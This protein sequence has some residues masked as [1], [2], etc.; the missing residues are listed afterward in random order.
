MQNN[1]GLIT[2]NQMS[3]CDTSSKKQEK[4]VNGY[5]VT[6]VGEIPIVSTE[7]SKKDIRGRW[8]ARWGIG[9]MSYTIEPGLSGWKS[10]WWR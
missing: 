9:R 1:Q 3:C 8:K 2:I 10:R 7:L 6:P 5:S 4:W